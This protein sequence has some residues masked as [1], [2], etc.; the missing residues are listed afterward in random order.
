MYNTSDEYLLAKR[1]GTLAC[2][3]NVVAVVYAT[4]SFVIS[5]IIAIIL[6]INIQS[7]R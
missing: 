7:R 6:L 3:L 1:F 5:A 2:R 4:L